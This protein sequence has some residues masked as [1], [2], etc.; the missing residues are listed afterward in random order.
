MDKDKTTAFID[1]KW[2]DWFVEGLSGFVKI[3]NL[4]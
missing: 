2:Q 4:T 1:E 3:P